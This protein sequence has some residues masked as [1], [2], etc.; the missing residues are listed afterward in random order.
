MS[1]T[2]PAGLLEVELLKHTGDL[3]WINL[4]AAAGTP[5]SRQRDSEGNPVYASFYYIEI[6]GFAGGLAAVQPEDDLEIV[7]TLA[8]YG[9][10][11]LDGE[12]RLYPAGTLPAELPDP[13]PPAPSV[14]LSNVLVAPGRG[15]DDLRITVPANSRIDDIPGLAEEPDSY[16]LIK[17]ARVDGRF[18]PI[19]AGATPLLS[20]PR[21][22]ELSINPDRDLNGVGI[23]YFA[24]YVIFMDAAERTALEDA[25][26]CSPEAL[27][28]RVTLSRRIGYYGN[29]TPR[30]TLAVELEAFR[31]PGTERRVLLHHRIRRGDGRVIAVAS[32]E[33]LLPA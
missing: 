12:H 13:L 14:R 8:R 4:G 21:T 9:R 29:T 15:P 17:Q 18:F 10:S 7:S 32:A 1:H 5:A 28:A 24:N 20:G 30:D 11:M 25:G 16:Q 6:A 23:L 27:D 33:K 22:V 19:P 31:M 2:G 3:Q 26:V